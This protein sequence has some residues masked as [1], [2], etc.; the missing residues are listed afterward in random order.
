M[1]NTNNVHDS[2]H[3]VYIAYTVS[4]N[5]SGT[6]MSTSYDQ[7]MASKAKANSG[8]N[9]IKSNTIQYVDPSV[10][11]NALARSNINLNIVVPSID[12]NGIQ[13]QAQAQAQE[14][15]C[16][17]YDSCNKE[18]CKPVYKPVKCKEYKCKEVC[19]CKPVKQKCDKYEYVIKKPKNDCKK[20][21]KCIDY[22]DNDSSWYY[23]K[24]YNKKKCCDKC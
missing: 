2:E 21:K 22:C 12:N 19:I 15:Y 14:Q 23:T 5:M 8:H 18:C 4:K 11:N 10:N 24:S 6:K 13:S 3:D 7:Y 9:G 20:Q 17:G 16:G 1:Y